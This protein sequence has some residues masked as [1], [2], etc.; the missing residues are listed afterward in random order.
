MPKITFLGA[1][2]EVGRSAVLIESNS[3]TQCILDY[4]VRFN[5][6]ERLPVYSNLNRLKAAALTHCHIDHSGAIPYLY[7]NNE[8]PLF[9]NPITLRVSEI[10]LEDMIK[11]S[12]YPYPFGYKEL[13]RLKQHSFFLKNGVRQ[14]IDNNF[15]LTFFNAGHIPGSVSILVQVDNKKILY[16][17]DLNT[18]PTNLIDPAQPNSMPEIDVLI[19]ES[20]YSTTEHP[21]RN[22]LEKKFIDNV[23]NTIETGGNVLIPAFGVARSQEIMLILK[24]YGYKNK[25]F[26]DG[27]AQKVA[28]TYTNF[29]DTIKDF[30]FFKKALKS[31]EFISRRNRLKI[32]KSEKNVIIAPSG[33]LKGGAAVEHLHHIINDPYSAIYLVGYQIEG[34]PGRKL[35]DEGIFELNYNQRNTNLQEP[36][37]IRA[38][39]DINYFDFSSHADKIHLYQYINDLTLNKNSNFIFCVHG[40]EKA[41]TNFAGDLSNNGFNSIAPEIG[42]TY[43]I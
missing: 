23:V 10:L 33:M 1:C 35:L 22:T 3:G 42:E 15:Y 12:N 21:A 31:V 34:T 16:T 19:I 4:G 17:G 40:D 36:I 28:I 9:T 29:P 43:Q 18:I 41:T 25:I 2:R 6:E 32:A 7:K 30:N 27:L 14:K 5:E 26:F 38:N 13:K 20:T 37:K 24:K 39:C 11:I 8:I